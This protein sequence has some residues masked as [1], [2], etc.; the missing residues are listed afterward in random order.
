MLKSNEMRAGIFNIRLWQCHILVPHC[1][2]LNLLCDFSPW[3]LGV[4]EVIT[5]GHDISV[6]N[7][8]FSG[9]VTVS[10]PFIILF[11]LFY[12]DYSPSPLLFSNFSLFSLSYS[13]FF[14][15][16]LNLDFSPFFPFVFSSSMLHTSY[17]SYIPSPVHSSGFFDPIRLRPPL[18]AY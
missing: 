2:Y 17:S 6:P 7:S 12:S 1:L 10:C 5:K 4:E 18:R 9:P 8:T 13:S 16:F 11:F 3:S 14:S 15:D